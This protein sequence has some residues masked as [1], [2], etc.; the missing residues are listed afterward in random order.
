VQSVFDRVAKGRGHGLVRAW[1]TTSIN[2]SALAVLAWRDRARGSSASCEVIARFASRGPR[3]ASGSSRAGD[4]R[5]ARA[6]AA[7]STAPAVQSM[8][9]DW[10]E[11]SSRTGSMRVSFIA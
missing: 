6:I 2:G 10:H 9:S 1:D 3:H 7:R 11:S 5:Y 8:C 4:R